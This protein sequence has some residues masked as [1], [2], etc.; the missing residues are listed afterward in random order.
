MDKIIGMIKLFWVGV[1]N[2]FPSSI[3]S[4]IT[5]AVTQTAKPKP[6]KKPRIKKEK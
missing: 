3:N 1:K 2:S 5:D 6:V 4:Q